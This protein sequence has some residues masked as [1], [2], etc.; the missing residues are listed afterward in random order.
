LWGFFAALAVGWPQILIWTG[1]LFDFTFGF[2]LKPRRALITTGLFL[3]AG[4]IVVNATDDLQPVALSGRS[5]EIAATRIQSAVEGCNVATDSV[6][7]RA[8][9]AADVFVPLIEFRQECAFTIEERAWFLR[10]L[11]TIYAAL[12]WLVVSLTLL[13]FSGVMRRDI[14]S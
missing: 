2:G 12:G 8:I 7:D 1:R 4:I 9:Y 13:T 10:L 3:G 11:K 5:S 6:I 14:Q